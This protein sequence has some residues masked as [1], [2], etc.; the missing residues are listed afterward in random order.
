MTSP[1]GLF[2]KKETETASEIQDMTT[3]GRYRLHGDCTVCGM[4]KNTFTGV[5]LIKKKSKEKKKETATKRH[6][7]D[8]K[9]T[10]T[11]NFR[12]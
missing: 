9:E 10:W 3:N 12:C 7:T 6:Q 11:E 2:C 8:Y 5:D 1:L 4:H